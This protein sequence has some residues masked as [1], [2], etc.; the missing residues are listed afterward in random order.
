MKL[1]NKQLAL[2]L[3][4]CISFSACQK[5]FLID[6]NIIPPGSVPDSNYLDKIYFID[7]TGVIKDSSSYYSYEYDNAKR[8]IK[9]NYFTHSSGSNVLLENY[10][11][12]YNGNDTLP[13][14]RLY[15]FFENAIDYANP[16]LTDTTIT[17]YFYNNSGKNLR[18]S[19]STVQHYTLGGPVNFEYWKE[20][21]QYQ[22]TPNG[23]YNLNTKTMINSSFPYST[24]PQLSVDTAYTDS[25]GNILSYT[26]H[27]VYNNTSMPERIASFTYDNN[28]SPL[29]K[30][31][32]LRTLQVFPI[33]ETYLEI[34]QSNNNRLKAFEVDVNT[35]GT[36]LFD[37]D[38]TGKYIYNAN[39]Y[40][41]RIVQKD[42]TPTTFLITSFNYKA[43]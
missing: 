29:A 33:G 18:D 42:V 34:M 2:L 22:Y 19:I 3:I 20:I 28:L 36:V 35:G 13:F 9:L 41:L 11:Y 40:P 10:Q 17:F 5:D 7:S 16:T 32:N 26:K 21:N 23:I 30:L 24:D 43:L 25:R 1:I 27:L 12:F 4:I 15:Y 37:E 6:N 31:S 8:V 38:L 14:K 39:G